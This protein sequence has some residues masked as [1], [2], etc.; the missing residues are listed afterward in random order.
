MLILNDIQPIHWAAAGAAIAG[1]TLLLQWLKNTSL[2]ISTSF[3]NMCSFVSSAPYFQREQVTGASGRWRLPFVLGLL[4]A[5]AVSAV[6]SGG[7]TPMWDLGM[8]DTFISSSPGVKIAWMF[9]GGIFI[10]FGTRMAGGCTSGHGIF[11][12]SNFEKA[13]IVATLSFMAAGVLTTNLLYRLI[14]GV[15]Q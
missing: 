1:I 14:L 10:G 4:A 15:S 3:E 11:G 7:W 6:T 13:S 9:A 5:G 2:G 8:F 12:M